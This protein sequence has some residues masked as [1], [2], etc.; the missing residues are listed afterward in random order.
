LT[1]FLDDSVQW[2]SLSADGL[3]AT[4]QGFLATG[5]DNPLELTVRSDGVIFVAEAGASL[6]FGGIGPAKITALVPQDPAVP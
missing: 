4:G 5:F 1:G 3:A 2:V 6:A